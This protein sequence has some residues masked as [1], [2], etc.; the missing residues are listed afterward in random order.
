MYGICISNTHDEVASAGQ[1]PLI[2]ITC[3]PD[4]KDLVCQLTQ[5]CI[6]VPKGRDKL[7][8]KSSTNLNVN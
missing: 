4:V 6:A 7:V 2:G 3:L 5:D 8:A 1:V